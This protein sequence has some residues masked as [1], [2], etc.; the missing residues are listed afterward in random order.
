MDMIEKIE[1]NGVEYW[2]KSDVEKDFIRKESIEEEYVHN[3]AIPTR[4]H[5]SLCIVYNTNQIIKLLFLVLFIC[6]VEEEE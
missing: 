5:N 3:E 6:N 4:K 2:K 1:I